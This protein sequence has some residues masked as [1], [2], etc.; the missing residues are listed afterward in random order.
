MEM[1]HRVRDANGDPQED[2]S[3]QRAIQQSIERIHC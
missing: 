1:S 2:A 3:L